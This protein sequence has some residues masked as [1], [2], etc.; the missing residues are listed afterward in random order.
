MLVGNVGHRR[1]VEHVEARIGH[2]LGKNAARVVRQRGAEVFRVVGIDEHG[3]DAELPQADI[4]LR[5]AAAVKR[6]RRD[7]AVAGLA[8]GQQ[9]DDLRRQAG[10]RGDR[11]T[12]AF[13]RRHALLEGGN[14]RVADARIDVAEGL[15]VEQAGRVFR[16]IENEGAGLVDRQRT[17][18]GRRIR[19]GAGMQAERFDSELAIR[20]G[21]C[22]D[23]GDPDRRDDT[24]SSPFHRARAH[25]AGER[26]YHCME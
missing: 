23:N 7:D 25:P 9:R 2:G 12:A 16:R 15:Q 17:R 26:R 13:E 18:A 24:R 1:D 6:T 21:K 5:E 10:G 14:G 19:L 22:V 20:H 3:L 4:E 11:G 8:Q